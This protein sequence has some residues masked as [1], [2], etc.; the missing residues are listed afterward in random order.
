MEISMTDKTWQKKYFHA[1][2]LN[3]KVN[4]NSKEVVNDRGGGIADRKS[5]V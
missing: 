3:M 5:H 1:K 4:T 2:L